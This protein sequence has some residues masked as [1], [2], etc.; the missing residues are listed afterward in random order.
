MAEKQQKRVVRL[1]NANPMHCQSA[2][3][4]TDSSSLRLF[5]FSPALDGAVGKAIFNFQFQIS[6]LC[7]VDDDY[8]VPPSSHSAQCSVLSLHC[9][10]ATPLSNGFYVC[11]L[12]TQ[13]SLS[14]PPTPT[15]HTQWQSTWANTRRSETHT[16]TMAGLALKRGE[17]TGSRGLG[18]FQQMNSLQLIMELVVI[19]RRLSTYCQRRFKESLI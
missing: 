8:R 11:Q 18:L 5:I 19:P 6:I 10:P 13:N 7:K 17:S 12:L 16:E 2:P 4:S 14:H 3:H 15:T 1:F 9:Q